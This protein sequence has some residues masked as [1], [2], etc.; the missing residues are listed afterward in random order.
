LTDRGESST[1]TGGIGRR[2]FLKRLPAAFAPAAARAARPRPN[3]LLV[4]A[5]EWRA[6]ATGYSGDANARTPALDRLAGESVHFENAVSGCAVCCPARASLMTGQ[7]PLTHGVYINDVP[8]EPKGATLGESFTCEGYRTGYIGKW[9]LYGSPDG[10]YGR[11]LAYIPPSKRFG[12]D[13][14]KACE[15]TH[16]YNHSLYYDGNDPKPKYW[17][18]YDALAQTG[19][20]CQF[21]ARQAGAPEPF[22]LTV[23]LG[24]PHFPYDTA[25]EPF[26]GLYAGREL[27]LRP[28]V[29]EI[30]R[31][32][33]Q[34]ALRGYYA[35]IAA[36]DSCVGSLLAALDQ[37]G[38]AEDTVVVFT[39][40]HGDMLYSQDLTTKLYPWEESVRV[41]FLLRYPRRLGRRGRRVPFLSNV[42]DIMPLL[43][44]LCGIT[45]PPG[46]QGTDFSKALLGGAADTGTSAFLGL[47]VPITEARRYGFAEYRG[48]RTHR[49]TYVRSIHG[50]WLLYDNVRDPYQK[51]NLCGRPEARGAQALLDGQLDGWLARLHDEFL[52]AA[53]YL[54]RDGLEHYR[55]LNT[56]VGYSR[57]PWG[58]WESTLPGGKK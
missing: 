40:D 43:L 7:Y 9:H 2:G 12:F 26:R 27:A 14:W 21:I 44:G 10:R 30:A 51:R 28:N 50:P 49:H 32:K 15:C 54:K 19:D 25:P 13:Y 48:V 45:I 11:R 38:A 53:A 22:F 18:G 20:A 57:S 31:D 46:V 36:L 17:P 8:L 52:P 5:D 35:H 24:P 55:E 33:A 47:P 4:L 3:V 42:P 6:Q 41:P 34:A 29:P 56:P 23:S 58:D 1:L 37:S 16:D 39:S